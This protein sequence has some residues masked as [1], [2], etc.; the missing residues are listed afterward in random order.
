MK[1]HGAHF[2]LFNMYVCVV[3]LFFPLHFRVLQKLNDRR[4][5]CGCVRARVI[6]LHADAQQT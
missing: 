1:M 5:R 2:I 6:M 3:H 4:A